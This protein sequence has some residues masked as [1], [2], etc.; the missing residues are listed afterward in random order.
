MAK[1]YRTLKGPLNPNWKGDHH[2]MYARNGN[3][4]KGSPALPFVRKPNGKF[5]PEYRAIAE[6]QLGRPLRNDEIVHH[7]DFNPL[8]NSPDNLLVC[9]RSEHKVI[10]G[11][12]VRALAA[13]YFKGGNNLERLKALLDMKEETAEVIPFARGI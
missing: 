8:N 13:M 2:F 4:Y 6:S 7:I 10:E 9:Q 1:H 11:Q 3:R 5:M 12:T